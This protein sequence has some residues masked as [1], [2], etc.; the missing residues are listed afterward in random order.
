MN[1]SRIIFHIDMNA[2]FC[3]VQTILNPSLKGKVFA[4]GRENTYKGVISTASYEARKKGIHSG[5]PLVEAF[6][7]VP[8]LLI[9]GGNYHMYEEYH[10][11]FVN[12]IKEYT[13]IIEVASIDELYADMTL[14]S[15]K[16]HPLE[17]A[18]EIQTRLVNE[19]SLPCSIGIAPTLF[20][21]KMGSDLKKPLGITVVRKREVS[22][23]LYPLSVKDIFGIGKKTYPRLIENNI[24]TIGDFMN[25]DNKNKVLELVGE[26]SYNYATKAISGNSSDVVDSNRY[27]NTQS[28]SQSRTYD[29]NLST[30][31]EIIFELRE[32]TK[33]IV[34]KMVS[35]GYLTKTITIT[36]RNK[37]FQTM[38]RSI[39]TD[40]TKD[41]YEIF[42]YVE[43]LVLDNVTQGEEYRLVGVSVSNLKLESDIEIDYNLFTYESILAHELELEKLV[44]TY[45]EKYGEKVINIGIKKK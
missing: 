21:A 33:V 11:R 27:A 29:L 38:T 7:L 30:T 42:D 32:M 12:L 17:L 15:L 13:S 40:Y 25:P 23:V 31:S 5:M 8:D 26:N 43:D 39:S 22:K 14:A 9:V 24:L 35:D 45:K 1:N 10:K 37:A 3:T 4:V 20:L 36:L 28:I 19:H 6:R 18:K 41:F 2:F 44:R 34:K 16:K